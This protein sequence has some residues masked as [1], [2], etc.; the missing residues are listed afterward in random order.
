MLA[1]VKS[2]EIVS[3]EWFDGITAHRRQDRDIMK[4]IEVTAIFGY[5][6]NYQA[7]AH[8]TIVGET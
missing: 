1:V 8:G 6:I 2:D 3:I 5:L 7:G 4:Y